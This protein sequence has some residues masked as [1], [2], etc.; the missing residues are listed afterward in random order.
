MDIGAF[1]RRYPPFDGLSEERLRAVVRATQIE[2]LDRS[3]LI[4]PN[5]ELITKLACVEMA[6]AEKQYT[7]SARTGPQLCTSSR[8]EQ[9]P[10]CAQWS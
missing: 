2:L 3:T 6:A 4:V 10:R 5:S 1:L 7:H 8:S 9:S